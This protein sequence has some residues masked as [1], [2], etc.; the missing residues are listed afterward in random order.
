[1][2]LLLQRVTQARVDVAGEAV[3]AINAGLLVFVGLEQGD[4][5]AELARMADRLLH[6]RVFSD[7][8]GRMN[9]D[10]T[11][12]PDAG[13]LLVSQFTL[14]A[15]T[16]RGR[17]PSFSAAMPGHEAQAAFQEFVALV[18]AQFP[19]PVATGRFG[20]DMQVSLTNNGPVTFLLD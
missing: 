13:L 18:R 2:K 4:G 3:G 17:R 12:V 20:A 5:P 1:M 9:L 14:A 7:E 11:E 10:V 8:Q 19:G 16:S 15:D 6:Y